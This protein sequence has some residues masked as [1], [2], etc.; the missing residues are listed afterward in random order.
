MKLETERLELIPLDLVQ[1]KLWTEDL[2]ALEKMLSCRYQ[3]EP[4]EDIFCDI[5]ESQAKL[6][7]VDPGNAVWYN[8]WFLIR[9]SDRVVVGSACFKNKPNGEGEVEIGYGLGPQHERNGYMTEAVQAMCK[10]AL[11]QDGLSAVIAETDLDNG[12][13]H[14]ILERCG[15]VET[16]RGE[17]IWWRL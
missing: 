4:V 3:A 15:F 14:R 13:S 16:Q 5:I 7:E 17:S 10:W 1:M 8:F 9:K 2:P 12:A 6:T 11:K